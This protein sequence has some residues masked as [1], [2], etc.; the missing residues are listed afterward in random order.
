MGTKRT[1]D[2]IRS[3]LSS[4]DIECLDDKYRG[5]HSIYRFRCSKG[6]QFTAFLDEIRTS[7]ESQ[8]SPCLVCRMENRMGPLFSVEKA[9]ISKARE[10]LRKLGIWF[11]THQ[12]HKTPSDYLTQRYSVVK[13]P[14]A[15]LELALSLPSWRRTG[16]DWPKGLAKVWIS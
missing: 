4:T 5:I 13:E 16:N 11:G 14:K 9:I 7:L 10:W 1:I 8:L 12:H 2:V 3:R 6:H 15:G